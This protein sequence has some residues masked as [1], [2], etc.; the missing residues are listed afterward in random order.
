[1]KA[2]QQIL[3]RDQIH[4]GLAAD[5]GVHLRQ[6]RGGNLNHRNA[7]HEDRRQESARRR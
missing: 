3:A 7:A 4:A 5:R 6:Q 1:M 2:A